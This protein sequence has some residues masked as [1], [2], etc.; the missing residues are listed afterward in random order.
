MAED[1]Q[2]IRMLDDHKHDGRSFSR[3][4]PSNFKGYPVFDAVPTHKAEQGT[5]VVFDD[6]ST[7]AIYVMLDGAWV[8]FQAGSS[9]EF[10]VGNASRQTGDGTGTEAIT[11]VGFTPSCIDIYAYAYGAVDY[12]NSTGWATST[13]NMICSERYD[14]SGWSHATSSS[15]V[16]KVRGGANQTEADLDSFDSDGFTLNFTTMGVNCAFIWKATK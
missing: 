15:L 14:S 5:M 4:D 12:S 7:E 6:G 8:A 16:I 2:I 11:G 10:K 13:S 9:N 3:P 1:K